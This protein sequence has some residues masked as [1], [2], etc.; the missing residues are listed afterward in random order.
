MTRQCMA[1]KENKLTALDYIPADV[2]CAQ[3]YEWLAPHFIA[4]DR[5]AY[6]SGGSGQDVTLQKNRSAF[7]EF[8][9]TPRTLCELGNCNTSVS[10]LGN[11]LKHPIMLAPVA[12]QKLVHAEGEL[13]TALAAES[14][15]T[16]MVSSTLST[17]TLEDVAA[18]SGEACWFQLYVQP[19]EHDTRVLINR[20]V[21]AGYQAIVVT[22]DAAVQVPSVRAVRAGFRMP[23]EI[24][25]V[26][27]PNMSMNNPEIDSQETSHVFRTFKHNAVTYEKLKRLIQD[28]PLP[29]IV[30]GILTVED[31]LKIRSLGAEGIIVSNH[32]GRTLDGVTASLSVLADIRNALGDEFLILLDGGVRSGQDIYKSLALGANA[33]LIGR[34][35]MYALSVAGALG[36]AHMIKLL[37]EELEL[38]MAM[39]GR[40]NVSDIRSDDVN[41]N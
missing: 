8:N 11:R 10:I 20:A 40:S 25:A 17:Q 7:T 32:G 37:R 39:T 28:S 23:H 9:I 31:A 22:V 35:Q 3:D 30:K 21:K 33:I 38:C 34:L 19:D 1:T 12:Y 15:D 24:T 36:V 27:L 14:T 29:V 2:S 13:A 5:F 6:I 41:K 18:Q 16:C 4:P 26:N